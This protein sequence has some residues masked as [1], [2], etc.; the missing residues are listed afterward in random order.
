V[1]FASVIGGIGGATQSLA[2]RS[3]DAA[4][5][6]RRGGVGHPVARS[7]SADVAIVK[8]LEP[9]SDA[10]LRGPFAEVYMKRPD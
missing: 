2:R 1:P 6:A 7:Q 5:A 4:S 3:A 10:R 9:V 8:R